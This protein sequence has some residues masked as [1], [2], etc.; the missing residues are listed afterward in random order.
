[1]HQGMNLN[2]WVGNISMDENFTMA[3]LHQF[4]DL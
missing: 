4:V 2:T 1:V 3:H